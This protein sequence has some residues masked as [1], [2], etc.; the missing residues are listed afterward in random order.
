MNNKRIDIGV[1]IALCLISTVIYL[2]AEQYT[3]RGVNQ[4]GPNFFPQALSGLMFIAAMALIIQAFRGNALEN[5]ESINKQGL[6][7]ATVTL[8]LSIGY[9]LLINGLG[10]YISTAVFLFIVMLHLGLSKHW[11]NALVSVLTASFVYGLFHF[12]LKIPL[13]EGIFI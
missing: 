8:T 6:I 7:R 13:P 3:G 10:F 5:F 1:G 11:L 12:F 9:L 4:Y 2:Y